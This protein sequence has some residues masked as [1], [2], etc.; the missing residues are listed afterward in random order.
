MPY[1][2]RPA[3]VAEFLQAAQREFKDLAFLCVTL[4]MP[5][6][7]FCCLS[8][9]HIGE[10]DVAARFALMELGYNPSPV[11]QLH[12]HMLCATIAAGDYHLRK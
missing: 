9:Q 7:L 8:A 1:L 12:A 2:V 4:A 5:L 11:K 6:S 3:E 10:V